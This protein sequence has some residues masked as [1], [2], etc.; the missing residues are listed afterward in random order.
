[1]L[2][3]ARITYAVLLSR[4]FRAFYSVCVDWFF[5]CA[6]T[7]LLLKLSVVLRQFPVQYANFGSGLSTSSSRSSLADYDLSSN[8]N[9][10][11]NSA[12]MT[13]M[14]P[15][16]IHCASINSD[17]SLSPIMPAISGTGEHYRNGHNFFSYLESGTAT[18]FTCS[19]SL[20]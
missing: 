19:F 20:I 1:M 8:L 18:D 17:G 4:S 6:V 9:S 14:T 5:I 2:A 11:P 16:T 10:L 13:P 7:V 12:P 15:M 3:L